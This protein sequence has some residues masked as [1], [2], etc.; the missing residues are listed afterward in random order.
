MVRTVVNLMTVDT[1][2][3]R[4]Q[5][6]TFGVALPATTYATADRRLQFYDRLIERV[7]AT[8]GIDRVAAVTGL[9]PKR[10]YNRFGT[11][12]QDYAPAPEASSSV[13]YYQT[14][15]AGYFETMVT[16]IVRGRPFER[17]DRAGA[18][19]AIVNEAFARTFWKGLDPIGRRVRPRF[20]DQ[21]P[22]LTV[23][24]VAKD[25]KQA[26]VEHPTGTELYFLVDQLPRVFPTIQAAR[27]ARMLGDGSMHIVLRSALPAAALQ[28]AIATAVREID[29]ALPII[30]FRNMDD[31][32]RDSVRRSRMLM[33]LFA[34]FAGLALLLAAIGVYGVLSYMVKQRRREIGIKMALGAE[35]SDV[36]RSV[37]RQ[38]LTFTSFGLAAGLVAALVL[39]RFMKS[40][41]FEVQADDPATLTGV[42]VLI[43]AVATAASSV[44]ALRATRV[45]PIVALKE[46]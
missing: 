4:S 34:G 26:G 30:Q 19:V 23:I 42:A 45:D 38:G 7:G 6:A 14:V 22:W 31:V 1:G 10:E 43:T 12:I 33:E 41:L 32:L 39:T 25:V 9:P 21:T 20:G 35:R 5:L 40:L 16:P 8:P 36:L 27:L 46:E 15:T 18:P 3:E 29:P 44:P 28:P 11:D 24:G 17:T 37:L 13:D 2:F